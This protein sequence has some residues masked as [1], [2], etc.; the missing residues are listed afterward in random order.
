MTTNEDIAHAKYLGADAALSACTWMTMSE[1]DAT[2][3][4]EDIDPEVL[5]RYQEPTLSGEWAG[6]SIPEIFSDFENPHDPNLHEAWEA[7]RDFVFP[8]ARQ[9]VA[10]RVLGR[11]SEALHVERVNEAK[12][13]K[14]RDVYM[15]S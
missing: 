7:G 2:S 13:N 11:V 6:E 9:A 3:I 5:D 1:S 15:N 8:E 12:V 4:L 10:L 14:L